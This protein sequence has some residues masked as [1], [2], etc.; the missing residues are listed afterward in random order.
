MADAWNLYQKQQQ[1]IEQ[2]EKQRKREEKEVI[3]CP[4]CGTEVLRDDIETALKI[5]ENHDE[6]RHSGEP[7]AKVNGIVP[8][9]FSEEEKQQIQNGLSALQVAAGQETVDD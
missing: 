7:T 5:A 2:A 3:K 4:D 8:P 6:N 9:Q 1:L